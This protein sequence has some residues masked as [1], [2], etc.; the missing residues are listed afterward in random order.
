[1]VF[2]PN[3]YGLQMANNSYSEFTTTVMAVAKVRS[4]HFPI[5]ISFV[6]NLFVYTP[7]SNL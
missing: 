3:A 6:T 1:M 2:Y 7:N 5:S 4:N